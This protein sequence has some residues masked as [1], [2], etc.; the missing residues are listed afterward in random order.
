[1]S[2]LLALLAPGRT[3]R[4]AQVAHGRPAR[5]AA[6]RRLC[7]AL[8]RRLAGRLR[9]SRGELGRERIRNRDLARRRR[10]RSAA[11]AHEREEVLGRAR[12]LARRQAAGLRLGPQR[13]APDLPDR[14]ARRRGRGAD[15][16]RGWRPGLRLVEGRQ[17][18]RLPGAGPEE[19]GAQG[20]GEEARRV[21]GGGPGPP[22]VAP[23]RDRRRVEEG[24][25]ADRR[26]LPRLELRLVSGRPRDR[27]RARREPGAG[28]R[29]QH[30]PLDRPGRGRQA[31]RARHPGRARL[32][33]ALLAGWDAG[34]VRKRDGARALLL[35]ERLRRG[36]PS[37]GR[38][39]HEPH[40]VVRRGRRRWSAGARAG[41]GSPRGR[42]RRPASSASTR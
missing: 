32:E 4:S 24:A 40:A 36:R 29:R 17:R 16:G 34:G 12:L 1:M 23:A 11:A 22:H 37:R 19:R 15:V 25:P 42:R 41:S 33:S 27:L 28:R 18:D 20:A 6:A 39:A 26:R 31:A 2:I 3:R 8:A 9:G 13:Q 35:H 5:R 30:R 10:G 7:G 38:S 14:P 21:R